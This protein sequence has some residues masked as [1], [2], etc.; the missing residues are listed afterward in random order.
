M[1]LCLP[2]KRVS[3]EA[4]VVT[5]VLKSSTRGYGCGWRHTVHST[6][7]LW[8]MTVL[9]LVTCNILFM[10]YIYMCLGCD[11]LA[12]D[13][14]THLQITGYPSLTQMVKSD[15]RQCR[16]WSLIPSVPSM[17]SLT[18]KINRLI[19]AY[20]SMWFLA[21]YY[22]YYDQWMICKWIHFDI[23]TS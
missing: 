19:N 14:I 15:F 23:C 22:E 3:V 2:F 20:I 7:T 13:V 10:H 9:I 1:L 12:L 18:Q 11:M 17:P 21:Q 4:F 5:I 8:A 6:F 16:L